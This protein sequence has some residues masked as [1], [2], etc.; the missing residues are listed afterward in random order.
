MTD[1]ELSWLAGYRLATETVCVA[2]VPSELNESQPLDFIT[3]FLVGAKGHRNADI[4]DA[5][6][7]ER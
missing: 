6:E 7:T 4:M 2:L 5:Q 1:Q 3:E